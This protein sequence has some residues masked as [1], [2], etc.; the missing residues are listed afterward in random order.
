MSDISD[1]VAGGRWP[2]IGA[3]FNNSQT[4]TANHRPP[5]TPIELAK[6][7]L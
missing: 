7:L 3:A 2:E 1:L 6:R 4:P 5:I